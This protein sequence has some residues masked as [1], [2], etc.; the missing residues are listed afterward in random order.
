M[1]SAKVHSQSNQN[2][3]H[4]LDR[5]WFFSFSFCS[6]SLACKDSGVSRLPISSK[7]GPKPWGSE[8]VEGRG[9]GKKDL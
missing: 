3:D 7:A 6:Q 8:A 4:I 2:Q 9:E 1:I 5:V